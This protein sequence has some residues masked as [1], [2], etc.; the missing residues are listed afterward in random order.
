MKCEVRA[1]VGTL[2]I[3]ATQSRKD[4]HM[5]KA[6]FVDI[7]SIPSYWNKPVLKSKAHVFQVCISELQRS[8]F[9]CS[10]WS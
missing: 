1:P 9:V 4:K 3:I 10:V 2:I 7:I 5:F 8:K 6:V